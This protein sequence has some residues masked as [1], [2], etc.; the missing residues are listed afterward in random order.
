MGLVW[1]LSLLLGVDECFTS[2]LFDDFLYFFFKVSCDRVFVVVV[3][4]VL[5]EEVRLVWI[6]FCIC[7]GFKKNTHVCVCIK[8]IRHY[9][10]Y[11]HH[12]SSCCQ[13]E[14]QNECVRIQ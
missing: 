12:Q 14:E 3:V 8:H 13:S 7:Y 1:H 6:L 4:I 9:H 10:Y 11:P 2:S 5:N